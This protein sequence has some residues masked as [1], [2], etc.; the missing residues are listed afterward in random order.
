MC[1]IGGVISLTDYSGLL[2]EGFYF[3]SPL[4]F[5]VL[6]I[7]TGYICPKPPVKKKKKKKEMKFLHLGLCRLKYCLIS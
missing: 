7:Y 1:I 3:S 5:R 2:G 4:D 6:G